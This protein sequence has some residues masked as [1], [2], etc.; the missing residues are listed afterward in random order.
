MKHAGRNVHHRSRMALL[1]LGAFLLATAPA[2]LAWAQCTVP[3]CQSCIAD[4]TCDTCVVGYRLAA[5]TCVDVN[6]C[7]TNAGGCTG[8]LPGSGVCANNPGSYACNCNPGYANSVPTAPCTDVNECG[9]INGGCHVLTTCTNTVGSRSCGAC[10]SGYTGTGDTTCNDVN[11]CAT[12]NGGC[13][14]PPAG[15]CTNTAGARVCACSTGFTGN[16][17]TCNDINECATNNGGCAPVTGQCANLPGTR[18]CTCVPGYAGSGVICTDVNECA[19]GNGGC[20]LEGGACTN[21]SGSRNCTCLSGYAGDG[22]T[23]GDINECATN[24]GGCDPLTTCGNLPGTRSCSACPSGYGG[25]GDTACTDVN[26]CATASACNGG[27]CTNGTGTFACDCPA[28][29]GGT[30]CEIN[31]Y[32]PP[33][34]DTATCEAAVASNVAKYVKCVTRC[35]IQKAGKELSGKTF[36]EQECRSGT[37]KS[38]RAAYDKKMQSLIAKGTCPGCLDAAAQGEIADDAL[39]AVNGTK[40]LAYCDGTVPLAP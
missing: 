34:K 29:F 23:C 38:C 5:N 35:R 20:A 8:G 28:G 6:E 31:G 10:P 36:D 17:L 18:E 14:T 24:G 25:S 32:V 37:A 40:G 33:D 39:A 16:G 9:T 19:T 21:T 3:L 26:E 1:V 27:T 2:R 4:P 22:V 7:A 15:S 12:A 30:V 11:E 13:A